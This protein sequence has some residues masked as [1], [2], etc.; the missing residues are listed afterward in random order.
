M[1]AFLKFVWLFIGFI[2]LLGMVDFM[3]P[4]QVEAAATNREIRVWKKKTSTG[5]PPDITFSQNGEQ[6]KLDEEYK[7]GE[8]LNNVIYELRLVKRYGDGY[9]RAGNL[10]DFIAHLNSP[11]STSG[12][13]LPIYAVTGLYGG[14]FYGPTPGLAFFDKRVAYDTEMATYTFRDRLLQ[15][16]YTLREIALSEYPAAIDYMKNFQGMTNVDNIT[17]PAG[18]V[19]NTKV[20]HLYIPHYY[21]S[22]TKGYEE[23]LDI[24]AKNMVGEGGIRIEKDLRANPLTETLSAQPNVRFKLYD[25]NYTELTTVPATG[26]P[27]G[28]LVTDS[29][30]HLT[31]TGLALGAT[32]Y[33]KEEAPNGTIP[34]RLGYRKFIA[35]SLEADALSIDHTNTPSQT[36]QFINNTITKRVSSDNGQTFEKESV[37]STEEPYLYQ[38]AARVPD[39]GEGDLTEFKFVDKMQKVE[40]QYYTYFQSNDAL[41]QLTDVKVKVNG[42][43]LSADKYTLTIADSD[44]QSVANQERSTKVVGFTLQFNDLATLAAGD[45]IELTV[46][47][48]LIHETI[49]KETRTVYPNEVKEQVSTTHKDGTE[50]HYVI[51]DV[52]NVKTEKG[53]FKIVKQ[54]AG[55]QNK[56]ANAEFSL[57]RGKAPESLSDVKEEDKIAEGLLTDEN[58][59]YQSKT[60]TTHSYTING[61]TI[62]LSEGLSLGDYYLVETLAPTGHKRLTK[63][64]ALVIKK[65]DQENVVVKTIDNEVQYWDVPDTG[66]VGTQIF[67]LLGMANVII[68]VSWYVI[69]GKRRYYEK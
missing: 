42:A 33:L 41:N 40:D 54:E 53:Y 22:P 58:G 48:I 29:S 47:G 68:F 6:W 38:I 66:G 4:K 52:A 27:L 49:T 69:Y 16:E 12:E 65:N 25:S 67:V 5:L 13:D 15:G 60:D 59:E 46:K 17:P 62:K 14:D 10:D 57:Y 44:K 23:V 43:A 32:Y 7:S 20:Y 63:P 30:G 31:I 19:P 8:M 36:G 64:I 45:K 1:K 35:S 51:S 61:K 34:E 50:D 18:L 9:H 11:D 56:L 3:Q 39:K 55:T 2:L 24:S 26:A 37:V 28:E 21:S